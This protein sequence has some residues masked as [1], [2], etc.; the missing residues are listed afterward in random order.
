MMALFLGQARQH[1]ANQSDIKIGHV[2]PFI[3][4]R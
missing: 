1:D 4:G 2:V 3:A